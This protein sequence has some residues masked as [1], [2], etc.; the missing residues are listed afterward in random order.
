MNNASITKEIDW[1][2]YHVVAEKLLTRE[3]CIAVLEA[4]EEA[5]LAPDLDQFVIAIKENELC[6]DDAKL[7]QFAAMAKE[8]AKVFGFPSRSVLSASAGVAPTPARPPAPAPATTRPPAPTATA[9]GGGALPL[10]T[11]HKST[12]LLDWPDLSQADQLDQ[13]A[14]LQLLT[15]FLHKARENHCSDVH[16]S[17]GA[18]PFVRRYK[19]IHLIPGHDILSREASAAINYAPLSDAQRKRFE[20]HHDLDYCIQIADDDRYR[21]NLLHHRLGPAGSYRVIDKSIR[22]ISEL[23]FKEPEVIEKLTAYNQGLI[24]LTGPAGCGKSS[25]LASLVDYINSNRQDHIIS[26]EDPIEIIHP[27]KGCNVNQ[28]EISRHTKSFG[29]ALRAA[30]REDPDVIVIG[31]M[32]DLETIEMAIHAS[33]TGHLVIGTLHTNSASETM[34]RILDVFPHNQQAQIRAMVAESLKAVICQELLPNKHENGVVLAAEILLGTLA[35]SNLIREGK[36]YQLLSTIQTNKHIGM[37]TMEQSYFDL[38]EDGKRSYDQTLPLIRNPDMIRQMQMLEA[39]RLK[40]GGRKGAA[41]APPPDPDPSPENA[42]A[43]EP[44]KPKR[45][46][47]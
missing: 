42:P 30:L 3:A 43:P 40:G 8:E 21:T 44:A 28:R 2:C 1:F 18:V 41:P 6:S 36:T 26:V 31:E 45:K 34:N 24:L 35:V 27:P 17:A 9:T 47:F 7:D 10:P 14:A 32:R 29:N 19:K 33:E 46:W 38:Y 23:G 12:W 16:I 20:E 13:D 37:V 25:T 15:D 5:N 11:D 4:F 39:Q 22:A